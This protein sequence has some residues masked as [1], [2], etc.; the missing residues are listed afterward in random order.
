[1]IAQDEMFPA[2]KSSDDGHGIVQRAVFPFENQVS[3]D[4]NVIV[5]GN[6][7]VPIF[8]NSGIHLFRAVEPARLI[9]ERFVTQV[10]VGCQENHNYL[11]FSVKM[12]NAARMSVT[13]QK[14]S[15]IFTS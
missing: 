4:K 8:L 6:K 2:F 10:Q 5:L 13:M 7:I 15:T 11:I 12:V 3:K 1:M 14:R 9:D